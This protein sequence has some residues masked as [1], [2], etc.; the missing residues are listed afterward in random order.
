MFEGKNIIPKPENEPIL[1]YL[2]GSPEKSLVK[3]AIN[4]IKNTSLE[5][6]LIINGKKIRTGNVISSIMPHDHHQ[7]LAKYHKATEEE[8]HRAID[9]ALLSRKIW[10]KIPWYD[11]AAIFLKAADLLSG[12]YRS[13]VTAATMLSIGKTI[14]QAEIDIAELIDFWRFNVFYM[15]KVYENQPFNALHELNRLDYRPLEGFVFAVT[16][17]NFL[18]IMGNL[19]T[20]PAIMGNVVVWKPASTAIYPSY[21]IMDILMKAGLPSGVINFVPGDASLIGKIMIKSPELAGLHFTGSTNTFKTLW[22]NMSENIHVYRNFPRI[23]GETGGKDFIFVHKSA[24]VESLISALIRAAF[25]YS[26]Q[27]CSAASRSYIPESLWPNVKEKLLKTTSKLKMGDIEN[28]TTFLG[29]VIDK[30]AYNK[31][32]GYIEEV[33]KSSSAEILIGGSYDASRGY[34][35]EPTI[36]QTWDPKF[37]TMEE[38]I[39]GPILTI[40]VYPDEKY[41]ETLHLCDET[42]PYGL[43]G[44]IF[45]QD[46]KAIKLASEVLRYAAGNFYINNKPTAAVVGRQPFGGARAS[47]TND[48][49]GSMWNL[50]RWVSPRSIKENF[51]P[52]RDYDYPHMSEP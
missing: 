32:V 21:Y 37:K 1:T 23:V 25:Q 43:T 9:S 52:P 44:S 12:P 7:T 28:F 30:R 26:G 48:K 40:Y 18:S 36:I 45:A 42:S 3:I 14:Y 51:A 19:P 41:E 22:M 8:V 47:G 50:L 6:P 39:F 10:A 46:R 27:K 20:A 38:E 34:F 35:I 24:D 15:Q 31:I 5:I 2:H 17:F 4:K 33:K 11:R 49:A 29:A 16:P 13:T